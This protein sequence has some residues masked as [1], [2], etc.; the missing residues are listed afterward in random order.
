LPECIAAAPVVGFFICTWLYF[1]A[2]IWDG[3]LLGMAVVNVSVC[4]WFY[5]VVALGRLVRPISKALSSKVFFSLQKTINQSTMNSNHLD[6]I[7]LSFLDEIDSIVS[8]DWIP[9]VQ[10]QIGEHQ[11]DLAVEPSQ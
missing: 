7:L 3:G 4:L 1:L 11:Q 9:T 5:V 10:E 8:S 2:A 6:A